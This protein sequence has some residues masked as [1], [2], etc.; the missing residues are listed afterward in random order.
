MNRIRSLSNVKSALAEMKERGER[1]KS[2]D[3]DGNR[4]LPSVPKLSDL[5]A[6]LATTHRASARHDQLIN[7]K[8]SPGR[9][10]A[11]KPAA[12]SRH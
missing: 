5:G 2:G 10:G 11:S 7:D 3:A 4:S 1:Q 9:A 6:G 8:E 12:Q